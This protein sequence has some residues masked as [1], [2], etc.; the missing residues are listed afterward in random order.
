[1]R[2]QPVVDAITA[3]FSVQHATL[4]AAC[5]AATIAHCNDLLVLMPRP[6]S[7]FFSAGGHPPSSQSHGG[8]A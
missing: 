8:V 6:R 4:I 5:P 1:M 2:G 3:Q 7:Y